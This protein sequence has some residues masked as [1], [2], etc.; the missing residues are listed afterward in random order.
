MYYIGILNVIPHMNKTERRMYMK[1][2]MRTYTG[3]T[4]ESRSGSATWKGRKYE[5]IGAKIL[6]AKDKNKRVMNNRGYDLLWGDE[7]V[8]VKSSN[9][10]KEKAKYGIREYWHFPA[11]HHEC[12]YYLLFCLYKDIPQKAYLIPVTAV[13]DKTQLKMAQDSKKWRDYLIEL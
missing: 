1:E 8:D 3:S 9:L 6:K 5:V 4:T 13:E 12:D 10:R 7:R 11:L 2:Y